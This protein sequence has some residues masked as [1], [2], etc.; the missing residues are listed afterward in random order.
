MSAHPD[1]IPG[2]RLGRM[3]YEEAGRAIV[4]SVVPRDAY[5]AAF[6]GKGSDVL[7]FDTERSTDHDWGPRFQVF[8]PV[9]GFEQKASLV[10]EELKKQLPAEFKGFAVGVPDSAESAGRPHLVEIFTLNGFLQRYLA[11]SAVTYLTLLDWLTFPEQRLLELTSGEIFHDPQGELG[12]LRE[13]LGAYPRDVWLYRMACQWQ[14]LSQEEAFVGRC[15]EAGDALGM[16]V[17]AARIVRD[18]MKLCFLMERKYAPYDKWLGTAFGLLACAPRMRPLI[19]AALEAGEY[20]AL[21]PNLTGLYRLLGEMH[22]ALCVTGPLDSAPRGYFSRPY[23]V[24][25]AERFANALLGAVQ[26]EELRR[27]PV[28]MGAIDQFIDS[29]DFIE[30]SETYRKVLALYR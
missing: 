12:R 5:A 11:V 27:I 15:A 4:E 14:R 3:L 10:D 29:T 30:H 21:E 16:K 17:V 1:F 2:L 22:N 25:R 8:L 18:V 7:G 13:K 20:P 9:E 19:S 6:I 26:S 28:R 23:T 24:I